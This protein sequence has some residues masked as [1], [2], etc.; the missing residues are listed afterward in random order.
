MICRNCGFENAE[1]TRFCVNCGAP[2]QENNGAQE[3]FNYSHQN[4][5]GQPNGYYQQ[6]PDVNPYYGNYPAQPNNTPSVKEYLKWMILYPLLNFI[7][8]IGFIV[9]IL[10]CVKFAFD[11]SYKARSN[12]FKAMLVSMVIGI[13]IA[14]IMFVVMFSVLIAVEGSAFAV[15]E[16]LDPDF[17]MDEGHFLN[18]AG[19]FM[20]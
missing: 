17:F 13:G 19:I 1:G 4:N 12:F 15:L 11:D 16:E 20:K 7:P 9:Y 2:V 8:G 3:N 5:N 18:V 6:N 14:V 10:F